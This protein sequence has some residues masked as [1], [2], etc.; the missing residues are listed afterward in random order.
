MADDDHE[1]PSPLAYVSQ[2]SKPWTCG[3]EMLQACLGFHA[4][5]TSAINHARIVLTC[6]KAQFP[7]RTEANFAEVEEFVLA[8]GSIGSLLIHFAIEAE[9]LKILDPLQKID[10]S[11]FEPVAPDLVDYIVFQAFELRGV[12]KSDLTVTP[13][14][15]PLA[16]ATADVRKLRSIAETVTQAGRRPQA[17]LFGSG[18]PKAV[19]NKH[20]VN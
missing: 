18:R 12:D 6:A 1:H 4:I 7:V 3:G 13:C 16:A 10:T 5:W 20:D 17:V 9:D 2:L 19:R 8:N 14:D 11:H 15:D